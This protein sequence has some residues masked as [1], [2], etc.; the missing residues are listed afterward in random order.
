MDR[1]TAGKDQE[2]E[3]GWGPSHSP[4]T[5]GRTATLW[6]PPLLCRV[7]GASLI[8]VCTISDGLEKLLIGDWGPNPLPIVKI[9]YSA[10]SFLYATNTNYSF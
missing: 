9:N 3:A 10:V 1:Q 8:A 4:E 5:L 7:L 2:T 6:R